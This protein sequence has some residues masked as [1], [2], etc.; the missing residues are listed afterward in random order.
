LSDRAAS[1][2]DVYTRIEPLGVC[3]GILPFNFPVMMA[4][5]MWPI[6]VACGNT[7]IHKPSEQDPSAFVFLVELLHAAGLPPGVVNVVH[8]AVDMANALCD[9]PEIKTISFVGSTPVG[10]QIYK[11]ASLAGKRVQCMMGAKKP[12]RD[13]AG[14]REGQGTQ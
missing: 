3:A 4:T 2:I 8:G 9:H 5:F 1:G 14:C 12:W 11:R 6:A 7:W 10:N 13:H